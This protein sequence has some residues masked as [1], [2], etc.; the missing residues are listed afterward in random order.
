MDAKINRR[1]SLMMLILITF[2]ALMLSMNIAYSHGGHGGH[3]GGHRGGGYHGGVHHGGY[4][5][6]VHRGN[7][8]GVYRGGNR[9]YYNGG[10]RAGWRG[11]GGYYNTRGCVWVPAHYNRYGGY[12]PGH[13]AC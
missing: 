7:Y 8:H 12:V 9:V 6:G 1:P 13:R 10:Y 4:H 2:S 5:G 11:Y 3:G